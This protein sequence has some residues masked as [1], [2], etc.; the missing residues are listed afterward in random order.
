MIQRKGSDVWEYQGCTDRPGGI[1][2]SCLPSLFLGVDNGGFRVAVRTGGVDA[3]EAGKFSDGL[4]ERY[5]GKT[6]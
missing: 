5:F 4:C 1:V 6:L 2:N 3:A